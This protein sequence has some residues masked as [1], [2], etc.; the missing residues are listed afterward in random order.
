GVPGAGGGRGGFGG[1]YA[2]YAETPPP[3]PLMVR[4][5]AYRRSYSFDGTRRDFTE[6][7]AWFPALVLKDGHGQIDFELSDSLTTFQ[8]LVYGHTPDGRLGVG[9][10][11]IESRLPFSV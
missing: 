8:G 4:E 9:K 2:Y 5:F 6:T 10:V 1:G 3:P 11:E 7:L